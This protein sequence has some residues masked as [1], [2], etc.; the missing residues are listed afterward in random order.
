MPRVPSIQQ[1]LLDAIK[2]LRDSSSASLD[3]E[4]LLAKVLNKNR[5]HLRAW[6]EKVLN[7][8]QLQKFQSFLIER[9]K[10]IPI[11]YIMGEK[12]FWSRG[13][14]V[15]PDV[16]I[17]RPETELIIE[18]ALALIPNKP[19]Y[20]IADL[21]TG[22]GAI[23]I[24]L[25]LERPNTTV[26]AIDYSDKALTV[27]SQNAQRLKASNVTLRRSDWLNKV[28]GEFDLIIS[29]PPYI[30]KQDSHLQQGDVRFEP[31]SALIAENNGLKDIQRIAKQAKGFLKNEAYLMLEHGF[32]QQQQVQEILQ[33]SGY[34]SVKTHKD[35]IGHPRVTIAQWNCH[36]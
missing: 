1:C 21:G 32:D 36:S 17:P 4:V 30:D 13:F 24:T 8:S 27:A 23:A 7:E 26:L 3:S 19:T 12:E 11:A 33:S 34:T 15:T 22:S 29:N 2:L 9:A 25:G 28:T 18:L 6:P 14:T 20:H 10:G 5:A 35:L 31:A 16:L